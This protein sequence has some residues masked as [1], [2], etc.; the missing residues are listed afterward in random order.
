MQGRRPLAGQPGQVLG[1]LVG[2]AL[3]VGAV[4]VL[5]PRP[6]RLAEDLTRLSG[7]QPAGVSTG[8]PS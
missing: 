7:E 5:Y 8:D 4:L 6:D 3:A 1:Q 2:G